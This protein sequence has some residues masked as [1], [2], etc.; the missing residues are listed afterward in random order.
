[1]LRK[2]APV[3]AIP[4]TPA[5]AKQRL[6]ESKPAQGNAVTLD[7]LDDDDSGFDP[8]NTASLRMADKYRRD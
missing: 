7:C 6:A 1:M 8:Y 4:P 5:T 2:N 3:P